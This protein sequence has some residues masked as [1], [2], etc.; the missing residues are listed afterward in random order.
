[1]KYGGPTSCTGCVHSRITV[2]VVGRDVYETDKCAA[3]R[4]RPV[5]AEFAMRYDGICGPG[6][7]MFEA[8]AVTAAAPMVPG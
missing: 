7:R 4:G 8:P 2:T 6:R 5:L 3:R 1:M